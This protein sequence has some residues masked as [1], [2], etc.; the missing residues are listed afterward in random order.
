M[1]EQQKEAYKKNVDAQL[2]AW[3]AE[4]KKIRS[5]I[6]QSRSEVDQALQKELEAAEQH[7]KEVAQEFKRL[8]EQGNET[9]EK[10]KTKVDEVLFKTRY[11]FDQ[12]V[13]RMK[14]GD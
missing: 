14:G 3:Q 10:A 8:K 6:E 5:K 12:I 11:A 1:T 4:I 7:R 9:W 13:S 2:N